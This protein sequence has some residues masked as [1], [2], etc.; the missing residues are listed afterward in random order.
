[1]FCEVLVWHS[2]LLHFL[3]SVLKDYLLRNGCDQ[4]EM[5]YRN[6]CLESGMY[7]H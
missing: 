4:R 2:P 1:M 6:V 3:H 7:A 5:E